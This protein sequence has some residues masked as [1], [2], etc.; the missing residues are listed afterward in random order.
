M[1]SEILILLLP[2]TGALLAKP[3]GSLAGPRAAELTTIVLMS[4]ACLISWFVFKNV[5]LDHQTRTIEIFTWISSG[6]FIV[7]WGMRLDTMTAVMLVVVTSVSTLVHIYSVGYMHDDGSRPRFFAYLSLFTFAMLM[8]VTADNFIQLFFGW[9]GVGLASYLLIG[10]YHYKKSAN[11]AAIKAFVVNRVGDF[12]FIIGIMMIFY[13]FQ[14]VGFDEVFNAIRANAVVTPFGMSDGMPIR[15][16]VIPF[17]GR[18]VHALNAIGIFLFIGAM[19]KSAQFLLHTWLPDAM[20]GPTPVSALIHAATMVTA[21]VFLVCRA[22]PIYEYA[23]MA[24]AMVTLVGA[25]TA[26]FAATVALFQDDIKKVI[27]YSTCSQLGYMFF[28]AGVGAYDAAMFHLFTHAFFKALLFLGAG[29]VIHYMHH[30]QDM[31]LMGG[32][33]GLQPMTYLMMFIGTIAITGVGIPLM[34]ELTGF[35]VGTAGF[36]SK[37]M[38][39]ESAWLGGMAGKAFG[40][41][42]FVMGLLAAILTAFYSWRLMFLTFH[43][44]PRSSDH[45]LKHPHPVPDWM[46]LPLIPL[47]I[48]ALFSGM[49]FYKNFIG[50]DKTAFW[51]ESLY[52]AEQSHAP[53]IESDQPVLAHNEAEHSDAHNDQAAEVPSH[54]NAHSEGHVETGGHHDIPLWVL[55]APLVVML[56]GLFVSWWHYMRGTD[57]L[58]P[59]VMRPGGLIYD[60]LKNKWYFDEL[61][62]FLFLNPA[63]WLGRFLWKQGDGRLIDGFGP[64]GLSGLAHIGSRLMVRLQ[65]GYIYHYAFAMLIGI[66]TILLMVRLGGAA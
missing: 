50:P 18:D 29:C 17:L 34:V 6:N 7:N 37:D 12:G 41:Y 14:S 42:A 35:P 39:I 31:K 13:V 25:T 27:A 66:V 19:G 32:L 44:K 61:Y 65:S 3:V 60:F 4:L 30:E 16:L 10:F 33:R 36:V 22:S 40:M 26:F 51:G 45:I 28:A 9:E 11:D 62:R 56:I 24:S 15:E 23:P 53:D 58:R 8:L 21:G 64:D 48:G 5:A 2:L 46:L 57:P 38:I 52:F 54:S 59:G 55:I 63:R 20:E 1:Q 47:A 43:G 49:V